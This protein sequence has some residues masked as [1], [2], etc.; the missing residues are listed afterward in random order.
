MCFDIC[1]LFTLGE[2]NAKRKFSS[3]G[4]IP[5]YDL[6]IQTHVLHRM[7]VTRMLRFVVECEANIDRALVSTYVCQYLLCHSCMRSAVAN[8]CTI[9]PCFTCEKNV[10][11]RR[12]APGLRGNS[13]YGK[14]CVTRYLLLFLIRLSRFIRMMGESPIERYGKDIRPICKFTGLDSA[15][16]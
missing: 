12:I 5:H 15:F 10:S 8:L 14:P 13:L 3:N 7:I 16:R 2:D 6:I 11:F 9:A 1:F 4:V